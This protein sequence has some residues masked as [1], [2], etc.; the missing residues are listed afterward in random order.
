MKWGI[1]FIFYI[2]I[3]IDLKSQ[4]CDLTN[5]SPPAYF[6]TY[7]EYVNTPE[8]WAHY[9]VHDPTINKENE[10][11][12]MYSTDASYGNLHHTGAL[13]RRSK[14]LINWILS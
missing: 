2:G 6:D 14:D 3:I 12:Y 7:Y 10:W 9:N 13:K 5:Y 1:L 4:N 11:F 8:N